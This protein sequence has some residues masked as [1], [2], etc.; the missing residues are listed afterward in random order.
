[1]KKDIWYFEDFNFYEILCPFKLE[2]HLK[3]NPQHIYSKND[4]LFM[5]ED[6]CKEI[7]LIDNGK[8]KIGHYDPEG[9]EKIYA[10]LGKGEIMGQMALIGETNH[11]CFAEVMEDGTQVCKLSIEKARELTRDYVP[12]A[13]EM[14]RRIYGHIKKLE[15]RI[16]ILLFKNVKDRLIEFLKDLAEAHG[17]SRD[18]GI[19]IS[20]SLTQ[21]DIAILIGT[22]RKS[23]SLLL[24]E[25]EN[26]N[27]LEFDR[28]H[29]FIK[30]LEKLL[31]ISTGVKRSMASN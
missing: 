29:L 12:F 2:N 25:L 7:I 6:F 26:Q 10:F 16:E 17:R 5:E 28:K 1:M 8:V 27:L 20:H 30:D 18:G 3:T 14:N 11:R 23:V 31:Q 21:S 22:S 13:M 9:E 4:F 15:R 24:N 19:W